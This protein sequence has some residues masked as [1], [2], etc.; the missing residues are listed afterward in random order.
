VLL[1]QRNVA[2]I[3]N[4]WKAEALWEARVSP[5]RRVGDVSDEE[6]ASVLRSAHELMSASAGGARGRRAVYRRAGRP[7]R[8][9]GSAI[10][11]RGQSDDNRTAYWCP[12][13]QR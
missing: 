11:S 5:W 2:G 6:L 3:G 13:C 12:T 10:R 7:C 1:D 9:C 8:R 4:L